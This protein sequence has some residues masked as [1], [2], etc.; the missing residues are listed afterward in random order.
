MRLVVVGAGRVGLALVEV[1]SED[2]EKVIAVDRSPERVQRLRRRFGH[3]RV[4]E[5]DATDEAVLREAIEPGAD[6]LVAA[7]PDDP[8]NLMVCALARRLGVPN[9]VAR[10]SEE[11][12]EPLF[13]DVGATAVKNP[14]HLTAEHLYHAFEVPGVRT[15]MPVGQDAE[16]VTLVVGARSPLVGKSVR[17]ADFPR[18]ALLIAI[19]RGGKV[20]VPTADSTLHGGDALTLVSP[21]RGVE[22]LV[23]RLAGRPARR[24]AERLFD[25]FRG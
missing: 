20:T 21:T 25:R 6:A 1:A 19:N 23:G 8:T 18:G 13:A 16:V 11:E 2:G 24:L 10:V 4:L 22:A 15:F 12:A 9:V 3:V 7:T 17:E 14:S 5:G